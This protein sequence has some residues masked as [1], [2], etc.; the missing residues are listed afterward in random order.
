MDLGLDSKGAAVTRLQTRLSELDYYYEMINDY[1]D[2]MVKDAVSLYQKAAGLEVTGIA[3][4]ATQESLF[5]SS[6][7]LNE[8][9]GTVYPGYHS[10]IIRQLQERLI[11]LGYM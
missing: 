5:S 11:E 4:V 1:Y 10:S 2:Q 3:D 6:A 7:P 9:P 8:E